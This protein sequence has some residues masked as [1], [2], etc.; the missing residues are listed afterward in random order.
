MVTRTKTLV[1]TEGIALSSGNT[2]DIEDSYKY[3]GIPE[4]NGNHEETAR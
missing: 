2:A 3:L 4:A 1:R